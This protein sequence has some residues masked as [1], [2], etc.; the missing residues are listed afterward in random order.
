MDDDDGEFQKYVQATAKYGPTPTGLKFNHYSNADFIKCRDSCISARKESMAHYTHIMAINQMT[1]QLCTNRRSK[2]TS[3]RSEGRAMAPT[4]LTEYSTNSDE[5]WKIVALSTKDDNSKDQL[6]RSEQIRRWEL[7]AQKLIAR[8]PSRKRD[9]LQKVHYNWARWYEVSFKDYVKFMSDA[10]SLPSN[11]NLDQS[12]NSDYDMFA[13]E[14]KK[15]DNREINPSS[16]DDSDLRKWSDKQ[17]YNLFA[18]CMVPS[19]PLMSSA[20]ASVITLSQAIRAH[21]SHPKAE[22]F[23]NWI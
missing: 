13:D 10:F 4:N 23:L 17:W 18:R 21:T 6:D 15:G 8:A 5:I 22:Q 2:S 11:S 20:T 3:Q 16:P 7:E 12:H 1:K 14:D 9:K 19:P